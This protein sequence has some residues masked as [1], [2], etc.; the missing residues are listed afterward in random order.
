MSASS[1][2]AKLGINVDRATL[3]P[4]KDPEAYRFGKLQ[5]NRF[6]SSAELLFTQD[7]VD[8]QSL[9]LKQAHLIDTVIAFFLPGDGLINNN[10]IHRND[11]PRVKRRGVTH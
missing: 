2:P 9:S 6:W 3:F 11:L 5:E 10:L 8:Y 1:Q 7:R 4:I